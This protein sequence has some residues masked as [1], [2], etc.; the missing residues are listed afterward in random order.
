MLDTGR[1]RLVTGCWFL[2]TG[3]WPLAC[4]SARQ[5]AKTDG[6]FHLIP[7]TFYRLP[8]TFEFGAT[9]NIG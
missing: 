7:Y 9:E 6:A 1:W 5:S 8:S 2:V 4:M 3:F